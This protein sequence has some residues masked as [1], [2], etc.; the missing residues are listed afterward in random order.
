MAPFAAFSNTA[1]RAA[2]EN[3]SPVAKGASAEDEEEEAAAAPVRRC[4]TD[5]KS[6]G[7]V[8]MTLGEMA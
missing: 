2:G 3:T 8:W 5:M 6:P 7:V 1:K 4:T